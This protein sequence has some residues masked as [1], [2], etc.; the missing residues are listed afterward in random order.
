MRKLVRVRPRTAMLCS[1]FVLLCVAAD[2]LVKRLTLASFALGERLD[3]IPGVFRLTYVRNTGGAFSA[4]SDASWL[5]FLLVPLAVVLL[6]CL[7]LFGVV[8]HPVGVCGAVMMI[9]GAVGNFIDRVVYGYVVD[10]FDFYLINFAVFNL[11]DCFVTVGCVLLMIAVLF[12]AEKGG[13]KA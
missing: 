11:A 10:M 3:V 6:L 8:R 1:V 5:F 4:F 7:L 9:G 2:L 12:F 13:Q